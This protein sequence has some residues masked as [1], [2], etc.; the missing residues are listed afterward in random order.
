MR[1]RVRARAF[2]F[3]NDNDDT[4][5]CSSRASFERKEDAFP[6]L[7]AFWQ[8]V[9]FVPSTR[10]FELAPNYLAFSPHSESTFGN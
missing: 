9:L 6:F 8:N 1:A 2:N 3:S 10:K 4:T 5:L 7:A